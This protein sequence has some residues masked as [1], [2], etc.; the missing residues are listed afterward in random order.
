MTIVADSSPL[1]A[2]IN[3]EHIAILPRL[4]GSLFIP[5]PILAE[6]S[7]PRRPESVRRFAA[8]PPSWLQIRAPR[9]N[10]SIPGLHPGEEAAINLATE[11]NADLLL[12]DEKEG[13]TVAMSR[14]LTV[15]GTVG[16][17]ERAAEERAPSPACDSP[18]KSGTWKRPKNLVG[19]AN[20]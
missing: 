5:P 9:N 19:T 13:R 20:G 18:N 1:V 15:T 3:I 17:L 11:L 8:N 6:L 12:M 16:L 7:S 10:P 14:G 4:F 2:L